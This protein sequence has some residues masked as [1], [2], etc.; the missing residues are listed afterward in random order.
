MYKNWTLLHYC[1]I[2]CLFEQQYL[3]KKLVLKLSNNLAFIV[4]ECVLRFFSLI[5]GRSALIYLNRYNIMF[6]KTHRKK[7]SKFLK[8]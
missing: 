8:L 6:V 5:F 7:I 3:H 1:C 2:F 4:I